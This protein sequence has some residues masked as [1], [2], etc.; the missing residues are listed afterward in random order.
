MLLVFNELRLEQTF[1]GM[2]YTIL[3]TILILE[4]ET[5]VSSFIKMFV[6]CSVLSQRIF[7]RWQLSRLFSKGATSQGYFPKW[8]LSRLFSQV[9]TSQGYFPKWQLPKA[10]F[11]SGNFPNV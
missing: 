4:A 11:P 8:Q 6:R 2:E 1:I 5:Q 3:N 10:I 7:P 9:A